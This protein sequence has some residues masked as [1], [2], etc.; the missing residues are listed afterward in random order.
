MSQSQGGVI[1][2]VVI[3]ILYW[4]GILTVL[5]I[6]YT[7]DYLLIHLWLYGTA[8]FN[9]VLDA[10]ILASLL[11]FDS[12]SLASVILFARNARGRSS[13]WLLLLYVVGAFAVLTYYT[14]TVIINHSSI[15]VEVYGQGVVGD[16]YVG[17]GIVL[18]NLGILLMTW[19]I[20]QGRRNVSKLSRSL[21]IP[22]LTQSFAGN[23]RGKGRSGCYDVI[24]Y[25]ENGEEIERIPC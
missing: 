4:G 16:R 21:Q 17:Y 14:Y 13:F 11:S 20:V 12:I 6:A 5:A 18:Y 8:T 25:D 23:G 7:I 15:F 2:G 24:I 19:L 9:I 22:L 3:D 1:P 10:L